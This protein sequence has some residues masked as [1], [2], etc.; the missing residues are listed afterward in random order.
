MREAEADG[1]FTLIGRHIL[2]ALG[3]FLLCATLTALYLETRE[4]WFRSRAVIILSLSET[5]VDGVQVPSRS[6]RFTFA[7]ADTEVTAMRSREFA[8][9]VVRHLSLFSPNVD[10]TDAEGESPE[11][12]RQRFA[13]IVDDV[14]AS[15]SVSRKGRSLAITIEAEARDPQLA[16]DIANAVASTYVGLSLSDPKRLIARSIDHYSTRVDDLGRE[17]SAAETSLA[18]FIRDNDLDDDRLPVQLR[19]EEERIR[20]VLPLLGDSLADRARRDDYTARLA[21]IDTTL[22]KRTEADLARQAR[23][24][25]VALLEVRFL[26]ARK[27]LAELETQAKF[28]N[29]GASQATIAGPASAPFSPNREATSVFAAMIAL[30]LAFAAVLVAETIR[31]GRWRAEDVPAI[32]NAP[33]LAVLSRR[34]LH[35]MALPSAAKVPLRKVAQA[36]GMVATVLVSVLRP[37]SGGQARV[38]LV[39]SPLATTHKSDFALAMVRAAAQAGVR[40]V[41]VRLDPRPASATRAAQPA[42][43]SVQ[44][45]VS[46]RVDVLSAI[47]Y[48]PDGSG[49]LVLASQSL[50]SPDQLAGLRSHVM[51]PL[52]RSCDLVVVD[53]PPALILNDAVAFAPLTD[54]AIVVADRARTD[55]LALAECVD[56]LC[57]YVALA[58]VVVVERRAVGRRLWRPFRQRVRWRVPARALGLSALMIASVLGLSGVP[59][60]AEQAE[61]AFPGAVGFGR[62]A[63]GWKGGEVVE[64]RS[65]ADS[66]PGT[67]RDCAENGDIPRIC[68]FRISGTITLF[69]PIMVGSNLYIAGQTAP[70]DGIQLRMAGAASGPLVLFNVHDVVIRF[71]KLRPGP[72]RSPSPTVDALSVENGTR[73]Y[74][75]NLSMMFSTDEIISIHVSGSTSSDI[76]LANSIVALS[77]DRANHPKGRHSK[78]AL[79]CSHEGEGN[80]CGRI[81]LWQNLF[82]HNRDRNPDVKGTA[83]G[84]IE[85]INNVFYDPISQFGEFYDLLG[86][87]RVA[88]VGNVALSGPST[89]DRTPPAVGIFR[90]EGGHRIDVA[91][92][93]NIAVRPKPCGDGRTFAIHDAAS[94]SVF[95]TARPAD[96]SAPVIPADQ[97]LALVLATAGD[98]VPAAREPDALDAAVLADVRDCTG[99]VINEPDDVGGWPELR[100]AMPPEDR[101]RD[102]LPDGWEESVPGLDPGRANDVWALDPASG[103]SLIETY[104]ATLAGDMR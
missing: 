48:A 99:R 17:L 27:E 47:T 29:Y 80:A 38:V 89:I 43:A 32:A 8:A 28:V 15:Y 88:Y 68:V 34:A 42:T 81:T 92:A 14:L 49:T 51:A 93:D 54:T 58:G 69:T 37:P 50:L 53:A 91:V 44:D 74:F 21:G 72:S 22:R 83:L 45:L 78:G 87:L 7:M 4:N 3:V 62:V 66:G 39:T 11:Q 9:L 2:L 85:I 33:C 1:P 82:A 64:V 101:D 76:T 56:E 95:S 61:I 13:G 104:L 10:G 16:A 100:S 84:P 46:G 90:S 67:L 65:I 60:K 26:T 23:A 70:G 36:Q 41:R 96:L 30:S 6:N 102:T 86:D 73:L 20:G 71:L 77:L 75:G 31:R 24:E 35:R 94:T 63:T 59:V 55:R 25:D 19:N 52:R 98:R 57:A 5:S 18:D 12:A 79:I 97:A 103:L 40:S